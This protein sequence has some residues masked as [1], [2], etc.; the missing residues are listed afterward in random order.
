MGGK[1]L[2]IFWMRA[3]PTVPST[4]LD[5]L[6]GLQRKAFVSGV[7]VLVVPIVSLFVVLALVMSL[8]SHKKQS[9]QITQVIEMKPINQGGG[10]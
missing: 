10:V 4:V 6:H 7:L 9:Q 8:L 3:S 5:A 2:P 1:V